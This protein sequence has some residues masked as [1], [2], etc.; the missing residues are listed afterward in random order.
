LENTS[1]LRSSYVPKLRKNNL[2]LARFCQSS[3]KQEQAFALWLSE[4]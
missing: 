3:K 4:A 2:T 1:R